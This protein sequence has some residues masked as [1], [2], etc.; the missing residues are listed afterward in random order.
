[1]NELTTL[2]GSLEKLL[3]TL[4]KNRENV[5]RELLKTR[6]RQAYEELLAAV[7]QT[8]TAFAK[9]VALK[10]LALN[11]NL[12]LEEQ[13]QAINQ[14]IADSGLLKDMGKC[15]FRQYD[16]PGLYTL[17][18]EL[19]RLIETALRPYVACE[20]CLVADLFDLER[21]PVIY[22][23]LTHK[24]YQDGEWTDQELDLRGKLL[25]YLKKQSEDAS[26]CGGLKKHISGTESY[27]L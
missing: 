3:S 27:F 19:G 9:K 17:A 4:K 23:T 8:A 25:V 26:G 11:P 6:Y 20:D 22:N 2:G 1:M 16:V 21:D 24:V 15:V 18:L 12:P 10:D 14:A 5:S 7:S 13:I